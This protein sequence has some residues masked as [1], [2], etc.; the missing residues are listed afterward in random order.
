MNLTVGY[1]LSR[2][3]IKSI[4]SM[5]VATIYDELDKIIGKATLNKAKMIRRYVNSYEPKF[6]FRLQ[7]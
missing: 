5:S 3:G 2:K 7:I 6:G 1:L 4:Q